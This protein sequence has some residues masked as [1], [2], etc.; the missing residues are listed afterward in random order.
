M[1][2]LSH[3]DGRAPVVQSG[4]EEVQRLPSPYGRPG[5]T[6]TIHYNTGSFFAQLQDGLGRSTPF[7]RRGAGTCGDLI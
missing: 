4:N 5:L 1:D 3:G 7:R 2:L 6:G